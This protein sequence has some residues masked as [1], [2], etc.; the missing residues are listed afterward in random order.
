MND[1]SELRTAG[2]CCVLEVLLLALCALLKS[3]LRLGLCIGPAVVLRHAA[4]DI[5]SICSILVQRPPARVLKPSPG[6]LQ[7]DVLMVP[8]LQVRV[9]RART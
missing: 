3:R 4:T 8:V 6:T 1:V 5:Y 9:Q 2:T 7:V